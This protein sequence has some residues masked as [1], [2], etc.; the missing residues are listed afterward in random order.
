MLIIL[1]KIHLHKIHSAI[2]SALTNGTLYI[3]Q[4]EYEKE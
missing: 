2:E 1:N 4:I 3:N